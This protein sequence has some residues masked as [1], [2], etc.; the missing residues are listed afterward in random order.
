MERWQ[1]RGRNPWYWDGP[2]KKLYVGDRP[3]I[4]PL[5]AE[6]FYRQMG[7]GYPRPG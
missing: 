3:G 1:A 5:K 7:T 2:H 4:G 6:Y